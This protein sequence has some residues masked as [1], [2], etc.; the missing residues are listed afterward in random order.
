MIEIFNLIT[1]ERDE[2]KAW[3]IIDSRSSGR[4]EIFTSEQLDDK[5][6]QA[7]SNFNESYLY[8]IIYFLNKLAKASSIFGY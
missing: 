8:P 4:H 3:F 7:F 5:T 6:L 1:E 2:L